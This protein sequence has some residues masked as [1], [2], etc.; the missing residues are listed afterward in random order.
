MITN[1]YC[2][3]SISTGRSHTIAIDVTKKVFAWGN[4]FE[5]A[6]GVRDINS[7]STPK[8]FKISGRNIIQAACGSDHTCF[9]TEE[10]DVFT[11]GRGEKGQ[12][13]LGYITTRE[14]RPLKVKKIQDFSSSDVIKSVVCGAYHTVLI[15]QMRKVYSF[16]LNLEG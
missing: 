10:N 9:L 8:E 16:G 4:S 11:C 6:I 12:L 2:I 15:T 3:S 5:G 13:G 7:S 1:L 14:F